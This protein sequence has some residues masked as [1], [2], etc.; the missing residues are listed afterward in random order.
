[1]ANQGVTMTTEPTT[2]DKY[3][4]LASE[5]MEELNW[6]YD[7][8][9]E[10]GDAMRKRKI[11]DTPAVTPAE[12][13]GWRAVPTGYEGSSIPV[14]APTSAECERLREEID[15]QAKSLKGYTARI[16]ALEAELR[17]AKPKAEAAQ[18]LMDMLNEKSLF[19]KTPYSEV[20]KGAL[21]TFLAIRDRLR[22][23][24]ATTAK[25]AAE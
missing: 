12:C 19:F 14:P 6:N 17:E 4:I 15:R 18:K 3:L 5:M 1:M 20:Q 9:P 8:I 7:G 23:L 2:A 25:E 16:A 21:E 24:L 11:L 22:E 10:L 13:A